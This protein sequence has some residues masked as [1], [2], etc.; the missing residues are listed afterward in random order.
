MNVKP[1][2]EV[3][4]CDNRLPRVESHAHLDWSIARPTR[5]SALGIS[6]RCDCITC[7]CKCEEEA[8]ALHLDL[9]ATVAGHGVS[10]GTPML[11]EGRDV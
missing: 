2:I 3:F 8:V 6:R 1:C 11:G 9:D 10:K 7:K 4:V 5:Q